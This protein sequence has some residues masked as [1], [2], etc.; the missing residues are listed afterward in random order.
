[1]PPKRAAAN[2][3]FSDSTRGAEAAG[4]LAALPLLLIDVEDVLQADN[5][6]AGGAT[7]GGGLGPV[8]AELNP[9]A[10]H[11]LATPAMLRPL[12]VS[13]TGA[14]TDNESGGRTAL[15]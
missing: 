7:A 3:S 15:T 2:F 4:T 14:D 13:G 6:G 12:V 5:A 1:M 8:P 11:L 9:L 10:P